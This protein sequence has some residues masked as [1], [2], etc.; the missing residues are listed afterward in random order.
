MF[1]KLVEFPC[2]P[3][4]HAAADAAFNALLES[5]VEAQKFGVARSGDP[6]ELA[7][8]AWS[9]VHGLSMLWVEGAIPG[10]GNPEAK[11]EPLTE[12]ATEMLLRGLGR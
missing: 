4:L 5:I 10:P 12:A 11:I 3:S 9:T 7:L 2:F 6:L 1:T 8:L